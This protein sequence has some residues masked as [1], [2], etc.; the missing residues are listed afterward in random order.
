MTQPVQPVAGAYDTD[1]VTRRFAVGCDLDEPA[2]LLV[3][4]VVKATGEQITVNRVMDYDVV[5]V[6][7]G[8]T[9]AQ[10]WFIDF[11]ESKLPFLVAGRT[12]VWK[13]RTALTQLAD[14][15][16]GDRLD[17]ER[18]EGVLDKLVMM[19]QDRAQDLQGAVR[20][21]DSDVPTDMTLPPAARRAS[22]LL[23]FDATGLGFQLVELMLNNDGTLQ[24]LVDLGFGI[25]ELESALSQFIL[26]RVQRLADYQSIVSR[27]TEERSTRETTDGAQ[28]AQISDVLAKANAALASITRLD[29]ALASVGVNSQ[30][31]E[32]LAAT[33]VRTVLPGS[34]VAL[35]TDITRLIVSNGPTGAVSM[36]S[37][38][39]TLF[40][41]TGLLDSKVTQQ[42]EAIAGLLAK[43]TLKTEIINPSDPIAS[44]IAEVTLSA[45][46]EFSLVRLAG[47]IIQFGEYR[48]VNNVRTFVP[49]FTATGEGLR[50]NVPLF[51]AEDA[52]TGREIVN[53]TT[54]KQILS[55]RVPD[56]NGFHTG[57]SE[58]TAI[59]FNTDNEIVLPPGGW[60][61]ADVFGRI[62]T[63]NVNDALFTSGVTG[64]SVHLR[65]EWKERTSATWLWQHPNSPAPDGYHDWCYLYREGAA[66]SGSN[67]RR[68]VG[69][70]AMR[71]AVAGVGSA[72]MP[73]NVPLDVRVRTIV[74]LQPTEFVVSNSNLFSFFNLCRLKVMKGI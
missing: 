14:F 42:A 48:T 15:T 21:P 52:I 44:R 70:T 38:F 58:I 7:N 74:K 17:V 49:F 71:S 33:F 62:D 55:D 26:D 20:I 2:D 69:A 46:P 34:I 16:Q 3:S 27:I 59:I 47:N 61:E 73:A 57:A 35:A 40:A 4:L 29:S 8:I 1:G 53:E 63:L 68:G 54:Q 30:Q 60:L 41:S 22:R 64:L 66:I 28:A 6:V 25:E 72:V 23:G 39:Q 9:G 10:N 31:A 32:A 11:P 18:L 51:V 13:R 65:L 43:L 45:N 24:A 12:L 36:A 56:W 67:R 37:W 50:L 5:S 19:A